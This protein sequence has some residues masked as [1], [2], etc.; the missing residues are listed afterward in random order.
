MSTLTFFLIIL[1]IVFLS[2]VESYIVVKRFVLPHEGDK[3]KRCD[4]INVISA[5][6]KVTYIF[7]VANATIFLIVYNI[8]S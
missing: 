4:K 7:G 6:Q 1:S 2:Y 3:Q 5:V 8:L